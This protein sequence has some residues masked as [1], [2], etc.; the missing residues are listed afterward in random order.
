MH[1]FKQW[2]SEGELH[3]LIFLLHQQLLMIEDF[4]SITVQY[5][6]MKWFSL[7]MYLF[8]PLEVTTKLQIDFE[9]RPR[10][11]LSKCLDLNLWE[12]VNV[13]MDRLG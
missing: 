10:Y 1:N 13:L 12:F 2:Y 5:E 4:L 3:R 6:N 8:I 7:S 11:R 9:A